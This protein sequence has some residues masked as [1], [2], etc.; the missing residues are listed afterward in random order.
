M[1]IESPIGIEK[2]DGSAEARV[3]LGTQA[4][5]S[6]GRNLIYVVAGEAITAGMFVAV[7][8]D[9]KAMKLTKALADD[10]HMIAC[11]E[12]ALASGEYGYVTRSGV[13]EGN[14][15]KDAV[16][17]T[18]FYT[19]ATAGTLDDDS[20]SQTQV[21]GVVNTTAGADGVPTPCLAATLMHS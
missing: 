16:I 13:F 21:L 6:L 10:K 19:S 4:V 15:V 2:N 20:S 9:F 18:A 8:E 1:S 11:A 5:A 12:V 7:D 17:D 3:A 14:I